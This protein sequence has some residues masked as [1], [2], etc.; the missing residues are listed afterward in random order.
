MRRIYRQ[1]I[2]LCLI[3]IVLCGLASSVFADEHFVNLSN[4]VP[5]WPY[6]DWT[7]AA[8]NIQDAVDAADSG[9]TVW[10]AHGVYATG[11]R[12]IYGAMTN[13]V[14]IAKP[15]TVRSVN[16][17]AATV[18]QGA[19]PIGDGAVRCVYV[20]TNAVL[21]GFT[22]T[23]GATRSS[24]NSESEWN[25]G[26]AWCETSGALSNCVLSGC[27]AFSY[28]GGAYYGALYDCA[29]SSNSASVAGGGA[30]NSVLYRSALTAN[31]ASFGGGVY[32]SA[33][34][35][36]VL[37]GNSA[38]FGGGAYYGTLNHCT[39]SDNSASSGGGGASYGA[40]NNC[41]VYYNSAPNGSNILGS[42]CNDCCTAPRPSGVGHITSEPLFV[43]RASGDVHLRK[44]SACI[45]VGNYAEVSGTKDFDGNP[46]IVN[47][48]VDMGAFEYQGPRIVGITITP[49]H[50]VLLV[51]ATRQFIA[52]AAYSD[53]SALDVTHQATWTSSNTRVATINAEGLAVGV[54]IGVT[55]LSATLSGVGDATTLKAQFTPLAITTMSLP[56]GALNTAYTGMLEAIDGTALPYAWSL[57]GGHLPPGLTL[58]ATGGVITGTPIASG[59]FNFTAQVG[60][61]S[62]P[63]QTTTK[64]LSLSV[65]LSIWSNTT[66]PGV[67]DGG[68]DSPVELGVKFR[69]DTTGTIAGICFYKAEAD[70]G[71]HVGNLWTSNGEWL[72]T[73]AFTNETASGWQQAFF[74]SPVAIT[75]HT[76]YV[77]SYH[78][79]HGHYSEDV[80]YFEGQGVRPSAASCVGRRRGGR[81]WRICLWDEQCFA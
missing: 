73:V 32:Y 48:V 39:L 75:N 10:V 81:Q 56:L 5:T 14:A 34:N 17:P 6:A 64:P 78:A 18:I 24:G 23:Q 50:S 13:R 40:L 43:D 22:L 47:G 2:G 29:L 77:A 12:A 3:G 26:G 76:I 66:A 19:G 45:D 71:P 72:A 33:L 51:E 74:D 61:A 27:S 16:G 63:S 46:R 41:I 37:L 36:C 68:P 38:S 28:G 58:D 55:M 15:V 7:T 59:H 25:G 53:G 49:A 62:S 57:A 8:T 80:G 69:S 31:S 9:D 35:N 65:A 44:G 42:T 67:A 1:G 70:T 52:M 21:S 11:G 20:G 60:D 30:Y 79:D 4:S 54:S